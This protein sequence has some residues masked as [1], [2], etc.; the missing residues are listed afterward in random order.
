MKLLENY[1][2]IK[3]LGGGTFGKCF[4]V[5]SLADDQELAIKI[6][7][8]VDDETFNLIKKE[9]QIL[10]SL[11]HKN[12]VKYNNSERIIEEEIYYILMELAEGSL[13]DKMKTMSQEDAFKYFKQISEG[14]YYLHIER[15]I[16]HRDLKPGNILMKGDECKICDL[17]SL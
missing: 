5:K 7:L 8:N 16:I 12:L 4:K 9:A 17:G 2:F 10:C 15:G 3:Y 1:E 14:L 11:N 13:I 6:I